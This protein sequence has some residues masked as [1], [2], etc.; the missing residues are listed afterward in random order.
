VQTLC[1]QTRSADLYIAR[2][3]GAE[4]ISALARRGRAGDPSPRV[5]ATA[6]ARFRQ[7]F[8]TAY[9]IIDLSPAIVARAM[10][11][12]QHR[13]LR[14]SDAVQLAGAWGLHTLRQMIG[15]PV[16]TVVSADAD[17][18]A[19]ATAEGLTVENPNTHDSPP[20]PLASEW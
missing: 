8:A 18:N 3:A 20:H 16:L 19:A 2:I 7:D 9:A 11:L 4:G 13:F 6:L 1:Q 15:L 10:D 14:G 5:L 17:L 12:A